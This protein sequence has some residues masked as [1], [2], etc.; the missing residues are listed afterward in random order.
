MDS[1]V[2]QVSPASLLAASA[3]AAAAS[4][5]GDQTAADEPSEQLSRINNIAA[6]VIAG[7]S[8]TTRLADATSNASAGLL[9]RAWL[10]QDFLERLLTGKPASTPRPA[11]PK[12]TAATASDSSGGQSQTAPIAGEPFDDS[13]G[14]AFL[15]TLRAS[16]P[17]RA[18]QEK[19]D[20]LDDLLELLNDVKRVDSRA[21]KGRANK[22]RTADGQRSSNPSDNNASD[23]KPSD[24]A[25]G[26]DRASVDR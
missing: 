1:R 13:E 11:G 12:T 17:E 10:L 4:Q 5:L 3:S 19:L 8:K 20:M 26:P 21:H 24:T 14:T 7:L 23:S 16:S 15:Q 18:A 25:H 22:A 2:A 6:D 9:L